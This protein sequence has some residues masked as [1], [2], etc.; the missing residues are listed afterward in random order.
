[1][2]GQRY[3]RNKVDHCVYF[4]KLQEGFFI[5]FILYTNDMLIASKSKDEIEKFK[6]LLNQ[7]F[8]MKDLGE[9]KKILDME[10]CRDIAH[11]KVSL[12]KVLQQFGM[13]EHI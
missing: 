11:D 5:Y 4:H 13:T 3:T 2:K 6:T 8:E 10:I 12:S 7:E 9:T 1:M